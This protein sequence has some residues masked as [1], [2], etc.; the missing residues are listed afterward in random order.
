MIKYNLEVHQPKHLV[1]FLKEKGLPHFI[2]NYDK[3]KQIHNR[4]LLAYFKRTR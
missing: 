2:P 3:T 1:D 4:S